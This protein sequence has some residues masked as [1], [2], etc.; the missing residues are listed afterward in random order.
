MGTPKVE[1]MNNRRGGQACSWA[2]QNPGSGKVP[3]TRTGALSKTGRFGAL[4]PLGP[5]GPACARPSNSSF[6]APFE[7]LHAS[8]PCLHVSSIHIHSFNLQPSCS[9]FNTIPYH[10]P[11]SN[12]RH[13]LIVVSAC[14][15]RSFLLNCDRIESSRAP[16]L[17]AQ[18]I[19]SL[20]RRHL[21]N[22]RNCKLTQ[23][24]LRPIAFQQQA[25]HLRDTS[26]CSSTPT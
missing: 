25:R 6:P 4:P 16:L 14:S 2:H 22:Q 9:V 13:L 7:T 5:R 12:R 19:H 18:S 11:C 21:R 1:A 24:A 26:S 10:L 15:Q 20:T 3:N 23:P 17:A 8:F